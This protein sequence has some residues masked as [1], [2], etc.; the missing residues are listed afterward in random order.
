MISCLEYFHVCLCV[1]ICGGQKKTC[2]N[3]LSPFTLWAL[4]LELGLPGQA[5]FLPEPSF[6]PSVSFEINIVSIHM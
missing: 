1:C 5:A 3:G 2:T 6:G 4:G